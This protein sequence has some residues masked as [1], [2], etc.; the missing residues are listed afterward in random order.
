M[1][2][3]NAIDNL[4]VKCAILL[5]SYPFVPLLMLMIPRKRLKFTLCKLLPSNMLCKIDFDLL[6]LYLVTI[7]TTAESFHVFSFD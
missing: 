6:I 2:K 7:K 1:K 5:F 4:K 3:I